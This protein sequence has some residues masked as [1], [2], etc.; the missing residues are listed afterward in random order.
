MLPCTKPWSFLIRAVVQVGFNVVRRPLSWIQPCTMPWARLPVLYD[1]KIKICLHKADLQHLC[2]PSLFRKLGYEAGACK[3][4]RRWTCP[5]S[6]HACARNDSALL[7]SVS[8][9]LAELRT[10][11]YKIKFHN[12]THDTHI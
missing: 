4:M 9:C 8:F 12:S 3:S 11:D 7:C 1:R 6:I 10:L 5:L 2:E